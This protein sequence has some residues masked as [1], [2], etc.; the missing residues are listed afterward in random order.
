MKAQEQME[1][2]AF[3]S[4]ARDSRLY[5]LTRIVESLAASVVAHNE[6]IAR[7]IRLADERSA[8]IVGSPTPVAQ[9]DKLWQA[10]LKRLPPQ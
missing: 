3:S 2:T 9:T 6:Q 5:R 1:R 8:E 4:V 7:L 10:Y